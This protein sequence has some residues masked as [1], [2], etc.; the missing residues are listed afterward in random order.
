MFIYFIIYIRV[1]NLLHFANLLL[2]MW[3][4]KFSKS[5]IKAFI[6]IVIEYTL[7]LLILLSWSANKTW[8]Y[9]L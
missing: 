1:L 5:L 3:L 7:I 2:I 9:F 8:F 4:I 6:L